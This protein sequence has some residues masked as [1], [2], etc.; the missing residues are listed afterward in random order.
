[1]PTIITAHIVKMK[2]KSAVAQA[3]KPGAT[4]APMSM[5]AM[6]MF[7]MSVAATSPAPPGAEEPGMTMPAASHST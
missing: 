3:R 6:S 1:M 4:V 2:A 5:L 7:D